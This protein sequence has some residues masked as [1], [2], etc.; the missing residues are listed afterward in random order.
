MKKAL[1]VSGLALV[2]TGCNATVY[3]PPVVSVGTPIYATPVPYSRP[4]VVQPYRAYR[5]PAVHCYST[6]DRTPY[7]MR[8]RR[9]CQRW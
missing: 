8:E 2:L 1:I 5:R 9:I 3:T 4:Y 6:W 7:G